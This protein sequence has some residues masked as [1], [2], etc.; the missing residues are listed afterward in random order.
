VAGR[1]RRPSESHSEL[2]REIA[3]LLAAGNHE[4]AATRA[5]EQLGPQVLG[6]LVSVLGDE[7]D[8]HEVFSR[9]SEELW[10]SIA[11]FRGESSFKTWAYKIVLHCVSRFHRDSYRR[12]EERLGTSQVAQIVQS[13][14]TRTSPFRRTE[15]KDR[16]AALRSR[17]DA[18]E[19]TLLFLRVDQG[20][21]WKDVTATMAA[22]G[23]TADEPALR[24]RFERLKVR[25]R[26]MA[27]AEGLLDG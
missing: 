7:D 24:K 12:R 3:A 26:E 8:G 23:E 19:Q 18:A 13:V 25:L 20:L 22:G 1:E 14:R 11:G 17:L 16:M 5:I 4:Q 2:E 15:V 9:F 21:S 27:E 6:Y 10:R